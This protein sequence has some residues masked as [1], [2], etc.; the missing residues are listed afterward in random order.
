MP[1]ARPPAGMPP[2]HGRYA[3]RL[4]AATLAAKGTVCHLCHRDGADSA[5]H[6]TPRSKGGSDALA[7]LAPAHQG[8]N[9]ARNARTLAEWFAANPLPH[10]PTLPPSRPW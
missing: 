7:N 9:S 5:D 4:V 10:R 1:S 3:Q 6:I 2:W 8:C